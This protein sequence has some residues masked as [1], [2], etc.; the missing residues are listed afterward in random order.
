MTAGLCT[1]LVAAA[2]C[3]PARV[4]LTPPCISARE[5]Y[6]TVQ[7]CTLRIGGSRHDKASV[8]HACIASAAAGRFLPV[9]SSVHALLGPESFRRGSSQA[10]HPF[11]GTLARTY[12]IWERSWP[13]LPLGSYGSSCCIADVLYMEQLLPNAFTYHLLRRFVVEIDLQ[14][15]SNPQIPVQLLSHVQLWACDIPQRAG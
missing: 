2:R 13:R 12:F 4:Y 8:L 14:E 1:V 3:R 9:Q 7:Y 10:L 11:H 15:F 6:S 5:Q